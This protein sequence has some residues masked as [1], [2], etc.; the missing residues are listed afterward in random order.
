MNIPSPSL[1]SGKFSWWSL[2]LLNLI[3]QI[4][5]II[6][7]KELLWETNGI[8]Q[9]DNFVNWEYLLPIII[10]HIILYGMFYSLFLNKH[11]EPKSLSLLIKVNYSLWLLG[12]KSRKIAWIGTPLIL[13]LLKSKSLETASAPC[14][15]RSMFII[16]I[17]VLAST[18]HLFE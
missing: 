7:A 15:H 18:I 5:V 16:A 1:R 4:R 14:S 9:W 2:E 10:M 6:Y 17:I 12:L 13:P 3:S 11:C 8:I